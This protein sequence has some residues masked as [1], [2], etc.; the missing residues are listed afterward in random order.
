MPDTIPDAPRTTLPDIDTGEAARPTVADGGLEPA[1]DEGHIESDAEAEPEAAPATPPRRAFV[2]FFVGFL[3]FASVAGPLIF[4]FGF[5]RYKPTAPQHIPE[6]STVAVRFDGRELYLFAPFREHVLSVLED[7]P[8]VRGR[9]ERLKDHVGIDVRSDVRE[10]VYATSDGKSFVVLV[11]GNFT[12]LRMNQNLL[13]PGLA[14]FFRDEGIEGFTEEGDTLKG[15]G[16]LRIA[17]ADDTTIIVASDDVMLD[18]AREPSEAWK[19]LGLASS[20][21]MSFVI[22]RPAIGLAAKS[23]PRLGDGDP[24]G[25][26]QKVVGY[27]TLGKDPE[28]LVDVVPAAGVGSEQLAKEI[29]SA[30]ESAQ[31]WSVLLPDIA[32]E[33]KALASARVKPRTETVLV[34]AAWSRDDLEEAMKFVGA[35]LR[36]IFVPAGDS[37]AR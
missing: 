33:K 9:A 3:L 8:G 31:L 10:V 21:V 26:T 37:D 13:V 1:A 4:Y 28:L 14:K 35:R 22:E 11:G 34:T 7:A 24:L 6:G 5:W 18:A 19:S 20:G 29:E 2:Y 15:P 17:Q 23:L 32:G 36:A 12:R 30:I 16:G 27:F 25:N